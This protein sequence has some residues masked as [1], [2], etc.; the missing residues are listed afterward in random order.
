MMLVHQVYDVK[1]SYCLAPESG[2]SFS[3]VYTGTINGVTLAGT[4][5][6]GRGGGQPFTGKRPE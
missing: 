6:G 1:V 2:N 3:Q 4:I 5:Q